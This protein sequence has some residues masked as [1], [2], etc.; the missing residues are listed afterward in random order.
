MPTRA[1]IAARPRPG[2]GTVIGSSW[3]PDFHGYYRPL[4]PITDTSFRWR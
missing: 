3:L 4:P 2:T 1:N